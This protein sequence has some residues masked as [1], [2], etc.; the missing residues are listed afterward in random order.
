MT[1]M[2]TLR[3]ATFK[4]M[5][6]E[7]DAFR[8]ARDEALATIA[9]QVEKQVCIVIDAG[10]RGSVSE[11]P[12]TTTA[13]LPIVPTSLKRKR[14][15]D[16]DDV[17][18]ADAEC[19]GLQDQASLVGGGA[20]V[21]DVTMADAAAQTSATPP[22]QSPPSTSAVSTL[23]D[24]PLFHSCGAMAE[25]SR[26]LPLRKRKYKRARRFAAVAVQTATA[27]TVGA[28]A[29]WSALAFS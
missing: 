29:T 18:D 17:D 15:D 9:A 16:E 22:P 11:R 24:H 8:V 28:I 27:V 1:E 5:T 10:A 23:A 12:Q 20:A 14:Q 26:S 21:A 19:E 2:R 13:A 4:H 6:A 3:E 7:L 25:S